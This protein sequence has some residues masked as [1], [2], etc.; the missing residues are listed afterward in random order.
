MNNPDEF[1]RKSFLISL[2]LFL[3]I[4]VTAGSMGVY[5]LSEAAIEH[6]LTMVKVSLEIDESYGSDFNWDKT[7]EAGRIAMFEKLDRYSGYYK[8]SQFENFDEEIK[9]SYSG[10]GIS[11]IPHDD[12]LLIMSVRE[13]GPSAEAGLLSGDIIVEADSNSLANS[14][15]EEA[16]NLLRG[17]EG[18]IVHIKVWRQVT[19]ETF[20]VAIIRRRIPFL[21][22]PFAGYTPDSIIYIR[23]LD[24]DPGAAKDLK[25]ALDSLLTN[26]KNS[27]KATGLILDLR[28][29]PGGLFSEGYMT[30]ELFLKKDIF[31]VGTDNR[32]RW[33]DKKYYSTTGDVTNGLPMAVIVDRGSASSAEIVAGALQQSGRAILVGDTTFGKGLV[34]GFVRFPG[35]DGLKLTISRYY[36]EGP[37]YLNDLDASLNDVGHGLAPDYYYNVSQTNSF[38]RE[39]E[40]SLLLQ[41]FAAFYQD[42]IINDTQKDTLN[43]NWVERFKAYSLDNKF[44]FKSPLSILA[45]EIKIL[46]VEKNKHRTAEKLTDKLIRLSQ[47]EEDKRFFNNKEYIKLRLAH[48]AYQRKEGSYS[49]YRNILIKHHPIIQ[50]AKD[51]LQKQRHD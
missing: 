16:V 31:I 5:V 29:N 38:Q 49:A 50:F 43:D 20:Q 33:N 45:K 39:L 13:N 47:R 4:I 7:I 37:I 41:Q 19:D 18:T 46:A 25:E 10:I 17:E 11:V 6:A 14:K 30:A 40:N 27:I 2:F 44:T 34:Q 9:G 15:G 36:F 8:K 21:H 3:L 48:I 28:N 22:I 32:S 35:G 1:N 51:I 12:G 23:L 24:F 42:D 26:D